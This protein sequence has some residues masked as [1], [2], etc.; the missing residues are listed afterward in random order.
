MVIFFIILVEKTEVLLYFLSFSRHSKTVV[1]YFSFS[2]IILCFF[3]KTLF[4]YIY[5]CYLNDKGKIVVST[6]MLCQ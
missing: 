2:V 3:I 5:T 4:T 6:V 1:C